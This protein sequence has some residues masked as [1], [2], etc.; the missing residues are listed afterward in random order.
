MSR[1]LIAEDDEDLAWTWSRALNGEGYSCTAVH[2]GRDARAL[3]EAAPFDLLIADVLMPSGGGVLLASLRDALY[4]KVKVLIV[5]GAEGFRDWTASDSGIRGVE[6][7]LFKPIPNA[8]LFE[9]VGDLIG[10]CLSR[11]G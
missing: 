2:S 6:K 1:I 5:T 3:L 4:P 9:V 11:A 10:A 8:V 7:V